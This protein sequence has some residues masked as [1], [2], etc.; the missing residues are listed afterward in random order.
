MTPLVELITAWEAYAGQADKPAVADF[1]AHYMR[2][3]AKKKKEKTAEPPPDMDGLIS[4]LVGRMSGMHTIYAKIM[5]KEW[6]DIELEWFY[7]LNIIKYKKEARKTDIISLCMME[8]STGIDI[9][10]RMKKK[11]L[12]T[13]KNDPADKRAKLISITDK[14][15]TLLRKIGSSLFKVSYILYHDVEEEDKQALIRIMGQVHSRTRPL[16]AEGKQRKIDDML[17]ERYGKAALADVEEG[18]DR[19]VKQREKMLAARN[20]EEPIDN[21]IRSLYK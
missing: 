8:Q 9:L 16:L 17:A 18:F 1:C 21:I 6:P 10:N 2:K 12:I 15:N 4:E 3:Q 20:K 7:L 11:A 14:G 19:L 13:E 5:M